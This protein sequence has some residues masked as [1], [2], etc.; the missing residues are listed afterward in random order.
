[1]SVPLILA[2]KPQPVA[3][4][5]IVSGALLL[6]WV[7]LP[8][9]ASIYP[10]FYFLGLG[11]TGNEGF[12]APYALASFGALA[13]LVGLTGLARRE[14]GL[15][16][17]VTAVL[18]GLELFVFTVI[19]MLLFPG[20]L[21]DRHQFLQSSEAPLLP[22]LSSAHV[23]AIWVSTAMTVYPLLIAAV[24]TALR[25]VARARRWSRA[26]ERWTIYIAFVAMLALG[27][28]V[29]CILLLLRGQG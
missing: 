14:V 19:A 15:L 18:V 9:L 5:V 26:R 7:A 11:V 25:A 2:E 8:P 21:L 4:R 22:P 13:I 28:I 10:A 20:F 23:A 27:A 6:F 24:I 16:L 1:M 29:A 3:L 17:P 12:V